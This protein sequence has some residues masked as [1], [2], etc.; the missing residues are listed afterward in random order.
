MRYALSQADVD[1]P[2][3]QIRST[4]IIHDVMT[5][6]SKNVANWLLFRKNLFFYM[7]R[8]NLDQTSFADQIGIHRGTVS[9]WFTG[10]QLPSSDHLYQIAEFYGIS[11]DRLFER[12]PPGLAQLAT[13]QEH[14]RAIIQAFDEILPHEWRESDMQKWEEYLAKEAKRLGKKAKK[15]KKLKTKPKAKKKPPKS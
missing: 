11:M 9:A 1:T 13:T 4:Y 5:L 14:L 6:S 8:R 3:S 2:V 12:V 7:T 10:A 15:G